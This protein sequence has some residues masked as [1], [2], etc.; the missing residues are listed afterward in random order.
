MT[1]PSPRAV[2]FDVGNTL[3]RTLDTVESAYLEVFARHGVPAERIGL[4]KKYA[5]R[6]KHFLFAEALGE[7]P[8]QVN[9]VRQCMAEFEV[10]LLAGVPRLEEMP[11]ASACLR[12]LEA[13]GWRIATASGFPR[14]VGRAILN[15]FGWAYPVVCDEDV[16]R[17][18]PAPHPVLHA[19]RLLGVAPADTVAV[20]DTPQDVLS[21]LA[22]GARPIAVATGK[23]TREEL[24]AYQPAA[25]VASLAEV[26]PL[27][28]D[29]A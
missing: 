18:R 5:G 28:A 16:A 14:V 3:V 17:H 4:F 20:G 6:P 27:L 13:R 23:F 24:A 9:L 29:P 11:G 19:C 25:V 12:A 10:I 1:A 8:D 7:V 21:A 22:A 15:R 26:P 2:L